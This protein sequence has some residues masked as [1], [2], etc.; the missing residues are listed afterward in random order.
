M[1]KYADSN[2]LQA[3]N[4]IPRLFFKR[5]LWL[6]RIVHTEEYASLSSFLTK[7][8][9]FL[10]EP[11]HHIAMITSVHKHSVTQSSP[12]HARHDTTNLGGA[13]SFSCPDPP[14]AFGGD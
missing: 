8:V 3:E 5:R 7:L 1:N 4:E 10:P 9:H 6:M 11:I 13:T 12:R 2:S 14:L